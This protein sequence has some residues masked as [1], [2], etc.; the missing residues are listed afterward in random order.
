MSAAAGRAPAAARRAPERRASHERRRGKRP[1]Q[2]VRQHVG[3]KRSLARGPRRSRGRAGRPERR[4][5]DHAAE[6]GGR[7]GGADRGHG[8]RAGR[9]EAWVASRAGRQ[10]RFALA[11]V[12]ALL[13]AVAVCL[14]L[15]GLHLH[16]AYA[17]AAACHPAGSA[18]CYE[19]F[20]SFSVMDGFLANGFI[21]QAV[22]ALIGAFVGAPVLAREMETGTFRYAWTQGFGRWRAG[23]SPSWCCSRWRWRRPPG[24]SPCSMSWNYQP[25]FAAG[26]QTPRRPRSFLA[27]SA[28]WWVAFAAGTCWPPS[29][30]A[31]WPACSSAGWSPA[32]AV[33]LAV[34]AGLAFTTGLFLRQHY[35][36]PLFDQQLQPVRAPRGSSASSGRPR[37][38]GRSASPCSARSSRGHHSS[39][40][41]AGSRSPST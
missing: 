40:G 7:P 12:A 9:P 24:C 23:R 17:A 11:G 41:K 35:L 15:I 18:I 37:A 20:S 36:T 19:L 5:Q 25:Y 4:R 31:P 38:A 34:Y 33:T 1:E 29:R 8:H 3:A 6:P 13:G 26:N 21:L 10:H 32:I 27:C 14:W 39:P 28:C 2:A 16:H 30:S 22:P